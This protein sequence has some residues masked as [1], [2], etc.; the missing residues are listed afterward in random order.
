MPNSFYKDSDAEL[1][2]KFDWSNWLDSGE[3]ISTYA[4]TVS[5]TLLENTTDSFYSNSVTV[6]LAGGSIKS[7]YNV[8]CL[9][10]TDSSRI[11]ERT[12]RI[13][14]RNR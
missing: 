5:S 1:D 3:S 12:I 2:Y 13:H 9:I 4:I 10:Q 7:D 14:V 8:A 6:W 11:D